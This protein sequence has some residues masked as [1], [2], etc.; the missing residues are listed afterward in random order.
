M[1]GNVF[2]VI[3]VIILLFFVFGFVF[4]V[5]FKLG[6]L[7]L[8]ILGILYLFKKVFAGDKKRY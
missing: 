1:S 3:I 6:L 5:L 4:R 8:L 7:A 2:K